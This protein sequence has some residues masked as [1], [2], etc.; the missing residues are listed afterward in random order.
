MRRNKLRKDAAIKGF[1]IREG[2]AELGEAQIAL[3]IKRMDDTLKYD[4]C[5][6][7]AAELLEGNRTILVKDFGEIF[8]CIS[9]TVSYTHLTL[10][11]IY[12]V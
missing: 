12:S 11:T 9:G 3:G 6:V 8:D 1:V 10:P 5:L 7:I 4:D 2:Q